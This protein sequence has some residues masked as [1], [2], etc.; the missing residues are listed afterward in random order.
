MI[1]YRHLTSTKNKMGDILEIKDDRKDV[2]SKESFDQAYLVN[3]D[4]SP[5]RLKSA[6][7]ELDKAAIDFIRSP[8]IDGIN[9]S[10]TNLVT[11]QTFSGSYLKEN[12]IKIDK[13]SGKH[14]VKCEPEKQNGVEFYLD[15]SKNKFIPGE[16]GLWC[17]NIKIW[18][19]A[20]HH[21]YQNIVVFEDDIKF[22]NHSDIKSNINSFIE[23]LP[24]SYDVA[25]YYSKKRSGN[26][27]PLEDKNCVQVASKKFL[28]A[29]TWAMVYSAKGIEKLLNIDEYDEPLDFFFSKRDIDKNPIANG[30]FLEVYYSCHNDDILFA[31]FKSDIR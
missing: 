22:K 9:I 2:C 17:S 15:T 21:N 6:T 23:E 29:C 1:R 5:L 14:L 24:E 10:I 7:T 31:P 25:F 13:N 30:D 18:Q 3:L 19:D 4:R 16:L 28:A 8:A 26:F 12:K 27:V 11:N 20:G